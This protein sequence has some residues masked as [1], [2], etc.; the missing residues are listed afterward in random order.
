MDRQNDRM[1]D[2]MADG[3]NYGQINRTTDRRIK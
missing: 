1:T 2:R 3:Q